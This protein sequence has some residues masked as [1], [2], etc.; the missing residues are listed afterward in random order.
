[1]RRWGLSASTS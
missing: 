1:M